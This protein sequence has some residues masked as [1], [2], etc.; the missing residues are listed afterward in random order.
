MK[1]KPEPP[2]VTLKKLTLENFKNF[3]KAELE[4]GPFTVLVGANATGKSNLR[5][6]FRFL[7]GI[8]RGYT[9]PEI[10]G[11]KYSS[12]EKVW[13]GIRGGTREL[14]FLSKSSLYSSFVISVEF[15]LQYVNSL[16]SMTYSIE[17]NPGYLQQAPMVLREYLDYD[18]TKLF[19][20][21]VNEK[22]RLSIMSG[23][24]FGLDSLSPSWESNRPILP[25]LLNYFEEIKG[26]IHLVPPFLQ[27]V[28][29]FS[30]EMFNILLISSMRFLEPNPVMMRLP[31]TPGQRILSDNGENLSSVLHTIYQDTSLRKALIQW[32][33]QL[34]PMDVVDFKFIPDPTGRIL[35]T[36]VEED[37]QEISAYSASDGTLRFLAMLAALLSPEPAKFYFF[38]E[39][40]TGIHPSRLHLLLRLLER[41]AETGE[42]QVVIT[43]HS[44]QLL[45][46][47]NETTLNHTSVL[48][49][50]PGRP[51]SQIK[52]IINIPDAQTFIEEQG[53]SKLHATH[54]FED[55]LYLL[56]DEVEK[57][58]A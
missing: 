6:A 29:V 35:L 37:G 53:F 46:F 7:H 14:K 25:Q 51:D 30:R 40:E 44:S 22:G 45:D 3:Q 10:I 56:D 34:T 52:K 15:E 2:K 26:S 1:N 32:V 50:L 21:V 43:T 11:E 47:V 57:V 58:A 8:G 20:A 23:G 18:E 27:A 5:E 17:V 12:G 54:W 39:F 24:V 28:N 9:L 36:L 55:V 31:S 33:Q 38:D 49:R 41:K 42:L 48:Y 4:L 19:E 16:S 13:S